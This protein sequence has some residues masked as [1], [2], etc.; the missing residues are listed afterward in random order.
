MNSCILTITAS[1]PSLTLGELNNLEQALRQHIDCCSVSIAVT[2]QDSGA[3]RLKLQHIL[4]ACAAAFGVT[5]EDIASTC[6]KQKITFARHAYCHIA[7]EQGY[8][9]EQVGLPIR[10]SHCTVMSSITTSSNL[11][12]CNVKEYKRMFNAAK[13]SVTKGAALI[14]ND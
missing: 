4:H 5:A 12:F 2:P 6:R 14:A 1:C 9:F 13:E 11:C 3:Q 8:T 10:R 7:R